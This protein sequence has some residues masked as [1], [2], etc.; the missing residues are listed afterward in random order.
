M[1]FLHG[2]ILLDP[3]KKEENRIIICLA[4]KPMEN[5][6]KEPKLSSIKNL[7]SICRK[8]H[9]YSDLNVA[10]FVSRTKEWTGIDIMN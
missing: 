1:N 2:W 6:I 3:S 7:L 5:V 10:E 9:R 8:R 4:K